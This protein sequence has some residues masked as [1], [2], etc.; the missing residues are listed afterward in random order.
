MPILYMLCILCI[1]FITG[2][3]EYTEANE[4]KLVFAIREPL[5][6]EDGFRATTDTARDI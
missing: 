3:V 4:G 2:E 6:N 5:Q 1:V